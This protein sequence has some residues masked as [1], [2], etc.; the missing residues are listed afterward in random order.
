MKFTIKIPTEQE[1]HET[2]R[3]RTYFNYLCSIDAYIENKDNL[4]GDVVASQSFRGIQGGKSFDTKKVEKLLR[5]AWITEMQMEMAG[6]QR[7]FSIYANHWA[8][9]QAYYSV[10]LA[11]R[12]LFIVM[13]RS[14][15]GGEHASNLKAVAEVISARPDLFPYPWKVLCIGDPAAPQ[16]LNLPCDTKVTAYSGQL[17]SV[18]PMNLAHPFR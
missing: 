16:Y 8:P 12:S 7:D 17:R 10:Y 14:D 4:I 5:N 11:L 13:G 6:R 3:F 2:H 18:I 9:V 15:L 1:E